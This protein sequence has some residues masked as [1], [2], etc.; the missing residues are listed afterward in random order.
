MQSTTSGECQLHRRHSS[1]EFNPPD[2][3]LENLSLL[4]KES[5][6]ASKSEALCSLHNEKLKL[7]VEDKQLVCVLCQGSKMH[8]SHNFRPVREAAPAPMVRWIH[9]VTSCN[10]VQVCDLNSS[11][12]LFK[13]WSG[14][15]TCNFRSSY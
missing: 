3:A 12:F 14:Q 7:C 11:R 5:Q 6:K 2:L 10:K 1:M 4:Q 13:S 9:N 15:E 8:K